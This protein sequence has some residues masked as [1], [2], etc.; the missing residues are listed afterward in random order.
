M[1][2]RL[3]QWS[4]FRVMGRVGSW[5]AM[6]TG[7]HVQDPRASSVRWRSVHGDPVGVSGFADRLEEGGPTG[8][9]VA[10]ASGSESERLRPVVE[11]TAAL[12]W[13][14]TSVL[15]KQANRDPIA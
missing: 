13:R 2:K 3:Q 7:G 6:V 11:R 15:F 10:A 8:P 4:R 5:S 14:A 12:A 1:R 9:A